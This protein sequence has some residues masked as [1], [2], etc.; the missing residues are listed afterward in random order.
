M[1][2]DTTDAI[3]S[4]A[5]KNV[6][7]D[8][9]KDSDEGITTDDQIMEDVN[10]R[11]W[12]LT[13]SNI[14]EHWNRVLTVLNGKNLIEKWLTSITSNETVMSTLQ[15]SREASESA[16][17][18]AIED[19]DNQ[20]LASSRRF[21]QAFRSDRDVHQVVS[22]I[23]E[24]E[25]DQT[26]RELF[27]KCQKQFKDVSELN[28]QELE[29]ITELLRQLEASDIFKLLKEKVERIIDKYFDKQVF[30]D[31]V[32]VVRS[33][34]ES[35]EL[36]EILRQGKSILSREDSQNNIH[37]VVRLGEQLIDKVRNTDAGANLLKK[38]DAAYSSVTAFVKDS[39]LKSPIEALKKNVNFLEEVKM[40]FIPWI[41][42]QLL[43]LRLPTLTGNKSTKLGDVDYELSNI[44]L[45]ELRLPVD[46]LDI[47][48]DHELIIN[49]NNI[50]AALNNFEW[51]Y[52]KSTFPRL[53]V[54]IV[55]SGT[56]ASWLYNAT[57]SWFSE[58]IK[59]TYVNKVA[60]IKDKLSRQRNLGDTNRS[61]SESALHRPNFH[62]NIPSPQ[63]ANSSSHTN[64]QNSHSTSALNESPLADDKY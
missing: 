53:R 26:V 16:L 33:I 17:K 62:L 51:K 23:K 19:K 36:A 29:E 9:C 6:D 60:L 35:E 34:K 2:A 61:I 63:V 20:L 12:K 18:L 27:Q 22:L 48:W 41:K 24:I 42:D 40:V 45:S 28:D 21:A 32:T 38:Q 15:E 54:E 3:V 31:G 7:E 25:E 46:C 5:I 13:K 30:Q 64:F 10:A 1:A 44:V 57:F 55:T 58:S 47:S 39:P 4:F 56:G 49:V 37:E 52:R 59:A 8:R 43:S 50:E 11:R 14:K